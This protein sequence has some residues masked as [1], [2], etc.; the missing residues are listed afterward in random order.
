MAFPYTYKKN[1]I[2]N[3]KLKYQNINENYILS[4][5]LQN[6]H[7]DINFQDVQLKNNKI[8]FLSTAPIL[9]FHY[10]TEIVFEKIDD[11]III[12]YDVNLEKLLTIV[13]V[14][15]ILTA[16]FSFVSIKYFL[17]L[18]GIL[19]ISIYS[20][21]YLAIDTRIQNILNKSL[22]DIIVSEESAEN[23]SDEQMKWINDDTRCSACGNKL[24]DY[25]L[26]CQECGIKLKRNKF[27]IPLDV[28]KYKDRP[29]SYHF[30]KKK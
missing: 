17:I 20:V 19:T 1:I 4:L 13:L 23:Y 30:K 27:T 18:A 26:Y 9:K 22:K 29:V 7:K 11:E 24:S 12:S 3:L 10:S 6:I 15:I 21:F 25:D 16:F 8:S 28:S 2:F 5:F 14:S